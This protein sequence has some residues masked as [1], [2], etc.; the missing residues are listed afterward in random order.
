MFSL[1][2]QIVNEFVQILTVF[3]LLVLDTLQPWKRD[4]SMLVNMSPTRFQNWGIGRD[5]LL[6]LG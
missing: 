1:N 2:I 6:G 5:V 4:A 3:P